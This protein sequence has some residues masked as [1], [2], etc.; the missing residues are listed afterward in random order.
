MMPQAEL[1]PTV[2]NYSA[3]LIRLWQ[4]DTQRPWRASVQSVRTGEKFFFATLDD[5]FVFLQEQTLCRPEK[6]EQSFF[7]TRLTR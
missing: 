2:P 7:D 5:L 6:A 1:F 3:Y 4:E